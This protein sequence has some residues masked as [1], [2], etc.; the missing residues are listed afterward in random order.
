[1]FCEIGCWAIDC[2]D[3]P[4]RS[5][6]VIVLLSLHMLLLLICYFYTGCYNN[7]KI[8]TQITE[9]GKECCYYRYHSGTNDREIWQQWAEQIMHT[10]ASCRT[11]Q[12]GD[13]L[14][15]V[16]L[17]QSWYTVQCYCCSQYPVL[18]L[19]FSLTLRLLPSVYTIQCHYNFQNTVSLLLSMCT[20]LML[21][22]RD[23]LLLLLSIYSVAVTPK[24]QYLYFSHYTVLLLLPRYSVFVTLDIHCYCYSREIHFYCL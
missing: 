12:S 17:C 18:L 15:L 7:N 8:V 9:L 2:L 19:L 3:K 23:T 21:L 20:V 11:S 4:I 13:L 22:S 14:N 16:N 10:A 24:I 6:C 1:M 5:N